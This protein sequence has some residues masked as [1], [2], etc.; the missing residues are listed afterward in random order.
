MTTKPETVINKLDLLAN[1]HDKLQQQVYK[2]AL[3]NKKLLKKVWFLG[4][5]NLILLVMFMISA[6]T[7]VF[8]AH[9][10]FSK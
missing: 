3:E 1:E 10:H 9:C 2:L 4:I 5:V 7:A 8:F 6:V